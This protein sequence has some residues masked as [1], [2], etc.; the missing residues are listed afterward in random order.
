M[1]RKVANSLN[2]DGF[3]FLSIL[4]IPA[5]HKVKPQIW[6]NQDCCLLNI[7]TQAAMCS[8]E[9]SHILVDWEYDKFM[10]LKIT[11]KMLL[12]IPGKF[13]LCF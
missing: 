12:K 5:T 3:S 6:I 11:W 2:I 4:P 7:Y 13:P 10:V 8:Q 1:K 9:K